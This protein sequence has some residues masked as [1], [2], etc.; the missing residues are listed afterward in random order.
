MEDRDLHHLEA[1]R[2]QDIQH[3]QALAEQQLTLTRVNLALST[4]HSNN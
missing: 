3:Q 1:A 4:Y 2:F